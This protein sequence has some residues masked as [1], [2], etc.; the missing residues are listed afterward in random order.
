MVTLP[1]PCARDGKG[2]GHQYGLPDLLER[3]P[4]GSRPEALLPTPTSDGGTAEMSGSRRDTRRPTPEPAAPV[5]RPSRPGQPTEPAVLLPTPTASDYGT[6]QSLSPGAVIRP[7]LSTLAARRLLPIPTVGA[8]PLMPTP[9][10]SDARGPARHGAGGADPRTAVWL[11]PTPKATDGTKGCPAQRGSKGDL[12]LP[13]AAVRLDPDAAGHSQAGGPAGGGS[14]GGGRLL[15]TPRVAATRTA[16]H[17]AISPASRSRPSLEQA[18]EIAEGTLPRELGS[19]DEAPA[20]WQPPAQPRIWGPYAQAVARWEHLLG[21]PAPTPTQPGKHGKPVLAP[22]FVEWLM[23][24]SIGSAPGGRS[25]RCR[26]CRPR[27]GD[28]RVVVPDT[29][30][31]LATMARPR[32]LTPVTTATAWH[33]GSTWGSIGRRLLRHPAGPD[34]DDE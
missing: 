13:S 27:P 32:L 16:R 14:A 34:T 9:R 25:T 10:T 5:H 12:T 21:R 4:L 28:W 22:A 29:C 20:A 19:W 33:K 15:P 6:N 7:S 17:A 23:G 11:L 1:T 30:R 24:L 26:S 3:C 8:A 31:A 2:P 18:A